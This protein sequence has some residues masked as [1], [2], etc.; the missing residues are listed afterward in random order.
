MVPGGGEAG[1]VA[2][3][4]RAHRWALYAEA[5]L[6]DSDAKV[7]RGET[8]EAIKGYLKAADIYLMLAEHEER[9]S[10]WQHY[11]SLADSCHRKVK[12]LIAQHKPIE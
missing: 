12:Q 5:I 11:I 3:D 9:Y 2:R 8:R 1:A 7:Q 10:E 6:K 4:P